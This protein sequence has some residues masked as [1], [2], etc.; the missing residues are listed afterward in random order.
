MI[1]SI[2][3]GICILCFAQGVSQ[4]L[5]LEKLEKQEAFELM[6]ENNFGIQIARNQIE[7]ADNNQNILNTGY[8]PSISANA[9][10]TFDT[11]DSRTDFNGALDNNGNPRPDV[12]INDAE[13][14][15]YNASLNLNYT[16]FDGLGR[17]YNFKQ[18]KEAYNL[19]ELQARE[20]IET[21]ALQLFTV[22]YEL[23]RLS[24][25][26]QVLDQTLEISKNRQIRAEY[27]FEYGQSNRLNLLNAQVDVSTDSINLLNA[28]QLLKNTKRDLNLVL[29]R[30]LEL[31]FEV[32]TLVSFIDPIKLEEYFLEVEQNNVTLLQAESNIRS[33]EYAVKS[34]RSLLLPTIGLTGSY[35]WNRSENPAS[36]FFPGTTNTSDNL[37]VGASLVWNLFDGGRSITGLRNSKIVYENQELL[38]DQLELQV[39]RDIANARGDYLNSLKIL[40]MQEQNVVTNQDNFNRSQERLKLGQ[41]T[42][43]EFR[44]AQLN[45]LNAQIV[46]NAA[47]YSAK[48]AEL[49]YLQLVG[50]L[51]NVDF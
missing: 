11:T 43:I 31:E 47:K 6:L 15:S 25:N 13:R 2:I 12:V 8:L 46:K 3:Y 26:V 1:K 27:Q 49:R 41:I 20:T 4:E 28:K 14:K 34:S 37:T 16:I 36:A 35:G 21:T 18:L 24:E 23:A 22:Y 48:I 44:Q 17:L 19:S 42:S 9:G 7:I 50:Q 38:K 39:M 45:L 30:D 29:N 5:G 10:G 32:D 51:L 33:S 40:K